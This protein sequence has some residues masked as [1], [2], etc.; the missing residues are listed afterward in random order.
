M[1]IYDFKCQDCGELFEALV[2][3]GGT[4]ACPAC[5]SVRLEQ[6]ISMFAVD[7]ASI[8]QAN[9]ATARKANSKVHRD[10]AIA[11]AEAIRNHDD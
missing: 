8:R 1:P 7:S 5:Q 6:Q 9:I 2:L 11:D 4:P 10:K 3:K